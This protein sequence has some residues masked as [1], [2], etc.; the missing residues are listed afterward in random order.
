MN[1]NIVQQLVRLH[2]DYK[3]SWHDFGMKNNDYAVFRHEYQAYYKPLI[4]NILPQIK[5][6][7]KNIKEEKIDIY[8]D[9][10]KPEWKDLL[11]QNLKKN[12]LVGSLFLTKLSENLLNDFSHLLNAYKKTEANHLKNH[13]LHQFL[14]NKSN[15]I[16][17]LLK[18]DPLLGMYTIASLKSPKLQFL[19]INNNKIILEELRKFFSS[20]SIMEISY[21]LAEFCSYP[22]HPNV[23]VYYKEWIGGNFIHI[24][25]CKLI[26]EE[27][28]ESAKAFIKQKHEFN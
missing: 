19:L 23:E 14:I 28:Y 11:L 8:L 16:A 7:L 24:K 3:K 4:D 21:A 13:F 6:Q 15:S 20:A 26:L 10:V 9:Y 25:F 12:N 22:N 2:V 1:E 18:N 5:K 17:I 27:K